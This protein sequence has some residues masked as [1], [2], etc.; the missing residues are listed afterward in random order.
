MGLS[1]EITASWICG[2]YLPQGLDRALPD[3]YNQGNLEISASTGAWDIALTAASRLGHQSSVENT[4]HYM[5]RD[6]VRLGTPDGVELKIKASISASLIRDGRRGTC[7]IPIV[8][9]NDIPIRAS[10]PVDVEA[11]DGQCRPVSKSLQ[12]PWSMSD[13]RAYGSSRR[14]REVEERVMTHAYVCS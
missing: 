3:D 5:E 1:G 10:R 11:Q 14:G 12:C 2:A 8:R 6:I 7:P 4:S 9:D 13:V